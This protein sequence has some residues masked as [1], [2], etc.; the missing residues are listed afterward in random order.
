MP[1]RQW[2]EHKPCIKCN[3]HTRSCVL[4]CDKPFPFRSA[5]YYLDLKEHWRSDSEMLLCSHCF[6]KLQL[7]LCG[8]KECSTPVE[9]YKK[10][11]L[12][13]EK[14]FFRKLEFASSTMPAPAADVVPTMRRTMTTIYEADEAADKYEG[15]DEDDEVGPSAISDV[16][17]TI[18]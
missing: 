9:P 17:P 13:P 4:L 5:Y 11:Y 14:I 16:V 7:C 15:D 3:T 10:E 18:Q 2:F 8:S 6:D 12:S 1:R